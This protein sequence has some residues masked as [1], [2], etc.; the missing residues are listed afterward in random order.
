MRRPSWWS[1]KGCRIIQEIRTVLSAD[2]PVMF[3]VFAA[4]LQN[5]KCLLFF[6][7]CANSFILHFQCEK[8]VTCIN[9]PINDR[10]QY[11]PAVFSAQLV[12]TSGFFCCQILNSQQNP[13]NLP[14][15][16]LMFLYWSDVSSG[17]HQEF[18]PLWYVLTGTKTSWASTWLVSSGTVCVPIVASQRVA[19]SKRTI[20]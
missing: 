19:C 18:V 16:L 1:G 6:W 12:F 7:R 17:V 14:P 20:C 11:F 2:Q 4:P 9:S 8:S 3:H 15:V 10:E 13:A 5:R